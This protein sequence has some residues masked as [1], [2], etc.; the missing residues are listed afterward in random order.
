MGTEARL[1]RSLFGYRRGDVDTALAQRE[2][3]LEAV[4]EEL[5]R[6]ESRIELRDAQ[7]EARWVDVRRGLRRVSELEQAVARLADRVVERERTLGELQVELALERERSDESHR[8]LS[9]LADD[10]AAVRRQARGQA[11]RIRLRALREAAELTERVGELENGRSEMRERLL[12]SLEEA[13][14][15]VGAEV[16]EEPDPS[17]LIAA[18]NGHG[19]RRPGELFEGLVE[20]E[21]GPFSDFSQL[22]GFEDAAGGIGATSEISVTRFTQ[23]RATLA[24]RFKQPVE[25]LHELEQRAPFEFEVRDRRADRIVLDVNE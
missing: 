25:L 1:R 12:D 9:A 22:V 21:V 10:L 6:A 7:L 14:K 3:E 19:P 15:R 24:M 11:T 2:G 18:A 13:V 23:G 16:E 17:G 20:V 8:A 5:E 4:E